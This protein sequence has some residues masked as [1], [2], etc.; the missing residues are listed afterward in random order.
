MDDATLDSV[1]ARVLGS[2]LVQDEVEFIWHAGEPLAAGLSFY[3]KAV[4]LIERH[5][6]RGVNVTN[7]IQTNGTLVTKDWCHFFSAHRFGL[8]L[9]VDGPQWLHDSHRPNWAGGGSHTR[10]M[11]GYE[12]L[13]EY[14]IVPGAICV[15]TRTSLAYPDEIFRFFLE[16]DF[17]SIA[18]NVEEVENANKTSSL[19]DPGDSS[20]RKAAVNEDYR[21]FIARFFDLWRPHAGKIMI[22]EFEDTFVTLRQIQRDPEYYQAPLETKGLGILTVSRDGSLTAFSPEFAAAKSAVFKDFVVGNVKSTELNRIPDDDVF[23]RM[24]TAIAAGVDNCAG[25][26][27]YFPLCG[28]GFVSNKYFENGTLESTETTACRL[29]RQTLGAVLLD[30]LTVRQDLS[31]SA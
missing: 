7:S 27:M 11:R 9:S 18:F 29:H 17:R 5:N 31:G 20:T 6:S 30:K 25:S 26:C 2:D 13:R 28:G 12:L 19:G 8:G 14:D 10:V 21:R 16:N 15:L 1:I 22:R 24:S 4:R 23:L 3:E